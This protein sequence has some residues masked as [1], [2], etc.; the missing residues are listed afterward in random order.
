S[1]SWDGERPE[2]VM[3]VKTELTPIFETPSVSA[4][5]VDSETGESL[6]VSMRKLAGLD[7]SDD[8]GKELASLVNSY[9]AWIQGLDELDERKTYYGKSLP[10]PDDLKETSRLLKARC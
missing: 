2:K 9:S 4:D 3:L 8:G 6:R 1:A 7:S 5:L 10:V